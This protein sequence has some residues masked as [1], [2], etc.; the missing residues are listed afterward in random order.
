MGADA[1]IRETHFIGKNERR[2]IIVKMENF[3]EKMQIMKKKAIFKDTSIFIE[4]ELTAKEKIVQ[5]KIKEIAKE[6]KQNG[7]TVKI[8]YRKLYINKVKYEWN[9]EANTLVCQDNNRDVH[10]KN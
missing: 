9:T 6:E 4:N 10:S 2:A 5:N 3:Q 1:N 7:N 8:G